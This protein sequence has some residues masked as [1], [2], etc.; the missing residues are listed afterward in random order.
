LLGSTSCGVLAAETQS[1]PKDQ[2]RPSQPVENPID[3]VLNEPPSV[4]ERIKE[5]EKSERLPFTQQ[6]HRPTY[7]LPFTYVDGLNR[8]PFGTKGDSFRHAEMEFQ[9]SIKF[10]ILKHPLGKNSRLSFGYTQRAFWQAYDRKASSPFRETDHEPEL[11]LD[12]LTDFKWLG[13]RN[14]VLRFGLDHQSNGQSD[15]LSRS[16]NRIYAQFIVERGGFAFSF[17]P[18]YRLPESST[19]DDNPDITHYMGH[20]EFSAAFKRAGNEYSLMLRN[21]FST[22]DNKGAFELG[23]SFPLDNNLRGYV[24][25]FRGYGESLV[26][27]NVLVTRVG[28]GVQLTSWL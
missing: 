22:T 1:P 14:R 10:P 2:D 12:F 19:T 25:V 24:Q 4:S 17:K 6:S 8:T 7:I 5:E 15:P 13:F 11:M 16:W 9:L 3:Q 20:G 26:D 18:W 27:Y 28:F 23:W 21:N